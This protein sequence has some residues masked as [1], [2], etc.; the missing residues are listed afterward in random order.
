M[1]ADR[2]ALRDRDRVV[3]EPGQQGPGPGGQ[4]P[5]PQPADTG[6]GVR[7]REQR[8]A[9]A[10]ATPRPSWDDALNGIEFVDPTAT[11]GP[12]KVTVAAA[13]AKDLHDQGRLQVG[14][15]VHGRAQDRRLGRAH[16]RGQGQGRLP[17]RGRHRSLVT[18]T[19]QRIPLRPG[20]RRRS[21]MPIATAM[22]RL[23][24]LN[25]AKRIRGEEAGYSLIELMI[26][27]SMMVVVLGAVLSLGDAA[28]R[29]TPKDLE[30]AH[31][32]RDTQVGL[33]RMTRELRQAHAARL[34]LGL[35]DRGQG[36]ARTRSARSSTTAGPGSTGACGRRSRR[37]PPTFR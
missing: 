35:R 14:P 5:G 3:P 10:P 33:H 16:L 4:E 30:R 11:P 21:A 27:A 2:A 17:R 24:A 32:I 37:R 7:Q 31:A 34:Q 26:V 13:G 6:R 22:S 1:L 18:P 19:Q 9:S 25:A 8:E 12:G 15:R 20:S 28:Q 29:S 36:V 23:A